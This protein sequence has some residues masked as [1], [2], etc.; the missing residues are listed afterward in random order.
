MYGLIPRGLPGLV[1]ASLALDAGM[2]TPI[3]FSSLVLMVTATTVIGLLLL[4][5]RLQQ[6]R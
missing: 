1:F 2:I 4:S 6:I 3:L 5:R